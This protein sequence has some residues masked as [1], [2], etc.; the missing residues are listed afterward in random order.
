MIDNTGPGEN[1]PEVT[2]VHV[3]GT[4]TE[5]S[6]EIGYNASKGA[7][8]YN[9]RVQLTPTGPLT[10]GP[11]CTGLTCTV[12]TLIADTAY[13]VTVV[14]HAAPSRYSPP[15]APLTV[16]TAGGTV[17]IPAVPTGLTPTPSSTSVAL[18]CNPD[19]G[20]TEYAFTVGGFP[21]VDSPTPS[22]T[23]SGLTASTAY[24]ASVSASNSAGSSASSSVVPFT[25]TASGPPLGLDTLVIIM[26]ENESYSSVVG[27]SNAPYLNSLFKA[28]ALA[29]NYQ[30]LA[31]PSEPNYLGV[32]AG[33]FFGLTSDDPSF[34]VSATNIVD[35]L[36]GEGLT[37][38]AFMES[39]TTP[40][41]DNGLY[42]QKHNPFVH[43]DDIRNTPAR[44]AKVQ[45]FT[46][47][48][49]A[50]LA[51]YTW[52]TPN[53]TDDGHTPGGS[54]GVA[55]SD[56][57]AAAHFPAIL[58]SPQFAAGQKALLVVVWDESEGGGNNLVCAFAGP[59]AAKGVVS[60]TLYAPGHYCLLHTILTLFGLTSLAGD[61]N[62]AMMTDMLA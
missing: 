28:G 10:V 34:T 22:A 58:N 54:A 17:T 61:A 7:T 36:E 2:G 48:N 18:A 21:A 27:S 9:T 31:H 16:T 11:D 41:S 19:T 14:A 20:A 33:S 51:N 26:E 60:K 59:M 23:V 49:P 13:I 45:P 52:I 56:K 3:I 37:W 43:Y 32:T 4:P 25:T 6:F 42:V 24:G 1:L 57:W 5:T 15:S 12:S 8:H 47:F 39:M 46:A 44:L 62:A 29:E 53:L 40:L 35:R 30:N 55:N 38:D 50:K